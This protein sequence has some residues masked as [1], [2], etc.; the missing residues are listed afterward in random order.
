MRRIAYW[1]QEY[2]DCG[3]VQKVPLRGRTSPAVVDGRKGGSVAW[4]ASLS[5]L[6]LNGCIVGRVVRSNEHV[7][8]EICPL[9]YAV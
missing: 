1:G 3:G 9:E 6:S 7:D 2:E 5:R 4:R 8:A